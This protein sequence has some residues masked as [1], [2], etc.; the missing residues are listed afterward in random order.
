MFLTP[1]RTD[2][3]GQLYLNKKSKSN[4][5]HSTATIIPNNNQ[6]SFGRYWSSFH[7]LTY[8]RLKN[9]RPKDISLK[10]ILNEEGQRLVYIPLNGNGVEKGLNKVV[11]CKMLKMALLDD[12]ING[13]SA[14]AN[15]EAHLEGHIPN[16]I[17]F[18]GPK[19]TG[20]TFLAKQL[21]EHYVEKGGYFKELDFSGDSIQDQ[22]YL[23]TEFA[24][25]KNNFL[26]SGREK[27]TMFLIDEIEKKIT[28]R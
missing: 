24:K 3:R 17:N 27:Y 6:V 4:C 23:E 28:R 19:G 5:K 2:L 1:I 26:L 11:G 14:A 16:G 25:A 15:G 10:D 20:K 22:K 9:M 12:V 8:D 13:L 7:C 21:G 18:F